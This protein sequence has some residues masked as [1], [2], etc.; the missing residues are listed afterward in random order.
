MAVYVV[1]E[2]DSSGVLAAAVAREY[3]AGRFD[4]SANAWLV[5][6]AATPRGVSDKL[7]LTGGMAGSQGIVIA[8]GSYFGYARSDTWTWLQQFPEVRPG[9]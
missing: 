7:G 8:A 1:I 4:L 6:D 3:G 5:S 9:G 2:T